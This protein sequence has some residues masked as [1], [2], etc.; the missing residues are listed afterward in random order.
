MNAPIACIIRGSR[1]IQGTRRGE[2]A[3]APNCTMTKASAKTMPV[4]AS[5]PEATDESIAIAT[6]EVIGAT[7]FGRYRCSNR[8][9][10]APNTTAATA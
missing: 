6:A 3:A 5:M 1:A 9:M 10:P 4:S 7:R 2:Y 8:G